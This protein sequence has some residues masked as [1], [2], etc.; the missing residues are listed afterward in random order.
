MS[1]QLTNPVVGGL[2]QT[3]TAPPT[4]TLSKL[5]AVLK[6]A[7]VLKKSDYKEN[8][9]TSVLADMSKTVSRLIS[10]HARF[11]LHQI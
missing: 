9:D 4:S 8:D 7:K 11:A 10:P 3:F 2:S 6:A 1:A 5:R